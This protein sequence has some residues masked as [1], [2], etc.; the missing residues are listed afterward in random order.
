ME[1][2]FILKIFT[3]SLRWIPATVLHSTGPLL[4]LVKTTDGRE[5]RR[6]VDNL[7]ARYL[8]RLWTQHLKVHQLLVNLGDLDIQIKPVILLI[9][10]ASREFEEGEVW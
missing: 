4:Y 2:L 7:R 5:I 8:N 1:I 6:H 9:I 10:T 3:S